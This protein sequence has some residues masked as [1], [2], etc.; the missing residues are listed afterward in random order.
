LLVNIF[1]VVSASKY[2]FI[3]LNHLNLGVLCDCVISYS[4]IFCFIGDP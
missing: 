1:W 3:K 4:V 2:R